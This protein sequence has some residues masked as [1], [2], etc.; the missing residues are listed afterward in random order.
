M[1]IAE[2]LERVREEI[3]AACVKAG[4]APE[5]V[6]LMAVSKTWGPGVVVEAFRAGQRLFGEN[7]VQEW[8]H[9]QKQLHSLLQEEVAEVEMHL[10]GNL[11]SN[12]T[13]KASWLFSAIDSV[14]TVK[15]ARRL[16]ESCADVG[17]VLPVLVEVKLSD[18]ESK[19]GVGE[20]ALT[21]LLRNMLEMDGIEVRGLMTVPPYTD[22]PE[23][24]RPYFRRL[25][26]LRDEMVRTIPGLSL[27]EL[28]MGM[29]HDFAVAIEEG[30]TCVRIGSAIFGKRTYQK[31]QLAAEA[32]V[33]QDEPEAE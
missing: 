6:R 8:E 3:A 13:S 22:D 26:E 29:S 20:Y 19:Q 24:A 4:R 25:R 15:V 9:K 12:K 7:K 17:K 31:E 16:S 1:S 27:P 23:G 18:E 30:S 2:N 32:R 21:G 10:I 14:D 28:S 11:Q 5:S 33:E